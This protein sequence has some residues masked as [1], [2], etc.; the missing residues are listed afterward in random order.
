MQRLTGPSDLQLVLELDGRDGAIDTDA[1]SSAVNQAT[2]KNV[3]VSVRQGRFDASKEI[4]LFTRSN[5]LLEDQQ[6]SMERAVRNH[7]IQNNSPYSL[8]EWRV[9]AV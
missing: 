3:S 8:V 6:Q 4:V 1:I 7:L 9:E 5:I 2:N